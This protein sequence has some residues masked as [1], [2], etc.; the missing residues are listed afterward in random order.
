MVL[1]PLGVVACATIIGGFG[2]FGGAGCAGGAGGNSG[3]VGKFDEG[4]EPTSTSSVSA[5]EDDSADDD[6][7]PGMSPDLGV[8]TDDD[9]CAVPDSGCFDDGICEGGVC[10]NAI[11]FAGDPCDDGDA[12]TGPDVCDGAGTC[13]GAT[14]PCAAPNAT[15]GACVDGLCTALECDAG[16]GNCNGDWLDGCEQVIEDDTNCGGCGEPC[17]PGPNA[18]AVCNAGTCER[19]CEGAWSNCDG[20][21]SNGCEIPEGVP[22]T[23]DVNGLNPNGCWTPWCGQSADPDARNFGSWYCFECSNCQVPAP[24][25]CQWCDH[26]TGLFYPMDVC[27]GCGSFEDLACGS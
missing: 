6:D 4:G 15:G 21:W 25:M 12:C 17:E 19:A 20:D 5:T 18:T 9:D 13:L 26:S 22:N 23:C 1:R 10:S 24:G 16:F 27:S 11:K 14:L 3:G 7:Q 2:G 8:C